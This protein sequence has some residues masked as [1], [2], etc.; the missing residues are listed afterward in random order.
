MLSARYRA[1]TI[2]VVVGLT[3]IGGYLATQLE[4]DD[5]VSV[6]RSSRSE[7]FKVQQEIAE[8][9]GASLSYM[10]AVTEAD[11]RDEALRLAEIIEQR[12]QPFIEQGTLASYDSILN[13]LPP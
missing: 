7:S 2:V 11:N 1:A 13:Y 6:L 5:T 9:F 8:R 4:F 3:A 12:L 10:M